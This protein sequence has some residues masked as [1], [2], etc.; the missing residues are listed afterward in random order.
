MARVGV[1]I[2][3]FLAFCSQG[4]VTFST[5]QNFLIPA[6][7][8]GS[9]TGAVASPYPSLMFISGLGTNLTKVSVTISNFSHVNPDD[10]DIL[11]VSPTGRKILLMSD[12][13]GS[14]N[15]TNVTLTFDDTAFFTLSDTA[16]LSSGTFK[17]SNYGSGDVFPSSAPAGPYTND[18]SDCNGSNPNGFWWL[19]IVDDLD[20]GRGNDGGTITGGWS[21]QLSAT[22]TTR[23]WD[24]G[25]INNSMTN[26][27][28]WVGDV[29]PSS[30]DTLVFPAGAP[31]FTPQNH[32][33]TNTIF[34]SI[35]FGGTN[36]VVTGNPIVLSG[37]ITT[38][39]TIG[40]N[41]FA[42][43]MTI[44]SP[45]FAVN[46]G[47]NTGL[48]IGDL[49][50]TGSSDVTKTGPGYLMMQGPTNNTFGDMTVVAGTVVLNKSVDLI[51]IPG[52]L[53]IGDG[54]AIASV[55]LQNQ[56]MISSNS[57]ITIARFCSLDLNGFYATLGPLNLT[58]ASIT[59]GAGVLTLNGDVTAAS[60]TVAGS[61]SISGKVSLGGATRTVNVQYVATSSVLNFNANITDG[62]GA[63]GIIKTGSEIL[64]LGGSN[65]F[66]GPMTVNAGVV[67]FSNSAAAGSSAS[68]TTLN[69]ETALILNGVNIPS[70]ALTLN[71]TGAVATATITAMGTNSWS[72]NITMSDTARIAVATTNDALTLSGGITGTGDFAI[73]DDGLNNDAGVVTL[74]GTNN[75]TLGGI[76]S[77]LRGKLML[78]KTNATAVPK[79]LV[80]GNG[81]ASATCQLLNSNQ[82]SDTASVGLSSSC[83]LDMNNFSDTVGPITMIGSTINTGTGTLTLNGA[84]SAYSSLFGGSATITG[85]LSLGGETR[86]F[87]VE[88]DWFS[89]GLAMYASVSDGGASAGIT[90]AGAGVLQLN[91]GNTYSGL[92]LMQSGGV[93]V[94]TP[95]ALGSA[96]SGT[97]VETNAVL[98]FYNTS[99]QQE[100][101]LLRGKLVAT[102]AAATN[103]WNGPIILTGIAE[104]SVPTT[105]QTVA[106]GGAVSGS[107]NV[108]LSGAGTVLFNGTATN[109][110]YGWMMA[111]NTRLLMARSPGAAVVPTAL[112]VGNNAKLVTVQSLSDEQ[113]A[114]SAYIS[115]AKGC[116]W[117]LN[118]KTETIYSVDMLGCTVT[119]GSGMLKLAGPLSASS[120]SVVGPAV[121]NGNVALSAGSHTWTINENSISP[122]LIMNGVISEY[123]VNVADLIKD[124]Y[125]GLRFTGSS[126]NT[127]LGTTTVNDG[128]LELAK[129]GGA[130]AI[131]ST[132]SV[133]DG[134]GFDEVELQNAN[135][136]ANSAQVI[137]GSSGLFDLNGYSETIGPLTGSGQVLL[138]NASLVTTMNFPTTFSGSFNGNGGVTKNGNA[139]WTLSGESSF[140]GS[141][142]INAGLVYVNALHWNS[143][144]IVNPGATLGGSGFISSILAM[145]GSTVSPGAA[146][147]PGKLIG[148]NTLTL[149]SGSTLKIEING[150]APITGYDQLTGTPIS[151][152]GCNLQLN[153][154]MGTTAPGTTFTIVDNVFSFPTTGIFEG[155]P[156][157]AITNLNGIPFKITYAGGPDGNDVV[158]TQLPFSSGSVQVPTS[159]QANPYPSSITISNVIGSVAQMS[160][161]LSNL[162]H[163]YPRDLD[164]LLVGPTGQSTMLMSDNGGNGVTNVTLIFHPGASTTVP[165]VGTLTS[166]IYKPSDSEP[167]DIFPAPAPAGP[168]VHD[169]NVFNG[170]DPNGTW[171]LYIIDDM[172][173]D[174]G[175]ISGWSLNII[176]G[177]KLSIVRQNT[178]SVVS[179]PAVATGFTL[180]GSSTLLT[181]SWVTV[182]GA[183]VVVGNQNVVTNSG[184]NNYLF[185]RLKK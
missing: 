74:S 120:S 105:N 104:I 23:V 21:L 179:W 118:N 113:I 43:A 87:T 39:N 164:V 117:D 169:L 35:I 125:G 94:S 177:P 78:A 153:L 146:A 19:Y 156:E 167:G 155:L 47:A 98:S 106:I 72:G 140:T 68:G 112:F 116:S 50:G 24:G 10:V 114:D 6:T 143:Q 148:M 182:P 79:S 32:F 63:A 9:T 157:G 154:G 110:F 30:G 97:E 84:V 51:A 174:S 90:K 75:N 133:G 180:E 54:S 71:S 59:T 80:I 128:K 150:P 124:G 147:G 93:E 20:A 91:G 2:G 60:S 57:P 58:G 178:N 138:T 107:G 134:N 103:A 18:L 172:A 22:G 176:P 123:G 55:K 14:T 96:T 145:G 83:V 15:A 127:Y 53:Y 108:A 48:V 142:T 37:G 7:G 159:G 184:T 165:D 99:I 109:S 163:S 171:S 17:P 66:S 160:V 102:A 36:Y 121:I 11:L 86:T 31:R 4:Q 137:V 62:G 61:S 183:P 27:Q 13:G 139:T 81:Y 115:I 69:P 65:T 135:Q 85:K 70:E 28:N 42:C 122:G 141:L 100:P 67:K 73:N 101:L 119:T 111:T 3:V 82:I 129:T 95:T 175:G 152:D 136:I 1:L 161:T 64:N 76:M 132:L 25:G 26:A 56:Q 44:G 149:N 126:A 34:G 181:N 49:L 40:T 38:T 16:K 185:Y 88:E 46:G 12:A 144:A 52:P 170:T 162:T 173:G 158:L 89:P 131:N 33:P 41:F 168:Y 8:G 29:L 92:T 166:G 45:T 151:L 77:V 130:T 5:G